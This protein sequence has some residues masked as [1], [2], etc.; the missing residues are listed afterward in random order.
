[1]LNVTTWLNK[2]E[3]S[4][5]ARERMSS[6][7]GKPKLDI[8]ENI[9]ADQITILEHYAGGHRL[10]T[11]SE[12][13]RRVIQLYN[14]FNTPCGSFPAMRAQQIGG[15]DAIMVAEFK[16]LN[17]EE[18]ARDLKFYTSLRNLVADESSSSKHLD[19]AIEKGLE[20][21]KTNTAAIKKV[22]SG[23]QRSKD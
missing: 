5:L 2:L 11:R 17:A 20:V 14:W 22:R 12:E 4:K 18:V 15:L 3:N 10:G 16:A 7:E 19:T 13:L 8:L 23:I 1:M 9:I 6:R 21:L